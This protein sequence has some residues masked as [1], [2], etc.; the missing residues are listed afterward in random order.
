MFSIL[1]TEP[2]VSVNQK[3]FAG[4]NIELRP[5]SHWDLPSLRRWRNSPEISREM[6]DTSYITPSQ[7]RRWFERITSQPDQ[8][9]WVVWVRGVR[10]GYMNIK[11]NGIMVKKKVYF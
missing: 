3:V 11:G 6:V 2:D 8:G 9:H 4:A 5:V 1:D 10:A 7:Q